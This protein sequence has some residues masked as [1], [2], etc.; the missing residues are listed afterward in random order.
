MT[1]SNGNTPKDLSRRRLLAGLAAAPAIGAIAGCGSSSDNTAAVV[2]QPDN[3]GLPDPSSIGIDHIVVVMM[4][5]RSFDHM[6]GWVPGADGVQAGR[7]MRNKAGDLVQ[8]FRLSQDPA[9]GFQ[10]C[11]FADPDHGYDGGRI[12]FNNGACDGFL[13]TDGTGANPGD[14]FPLGYY[15][16]DDLPFYKGAAENFTVCD[17]YFCG[18]LSSTIPNRVYM[19][20]G[21]TD[22]NENT[23]T[24]SSLDTIWDRLAAK[25]RSG[26]YYSVD[27]PMTALWGSK[28]LSITQPFAT[29][30]AEAALGQLPDVSFVDPAFGFSVGEGP[31]LSRDD[32]PH[33]DVRD[34]QAFLSQVYNALVASP[35]WDKTLLIINYDEWGGFADHV[36]PPLAPVSDDERNN[37]SPQGNDGRLGFRTPCFLIG[38]RARKAFVSHQQLDPN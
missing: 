25:G 28:H 8:S 14:H 30:L 27:L 22:R 17:R 35:A 16:A 15:T 4:E 7:S 29:F 32:H 38:P 33:A 9:Y 20:A 12:E 5:N 21:Q 36:P 34:G 19:H 6:L 26:T 24:V 37:I 1:S 31:G 10:G 2:P 3:S 13:L 18:I 23:L 11:N